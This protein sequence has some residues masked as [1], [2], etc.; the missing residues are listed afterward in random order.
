M[1]CR[2][3]AAREKFIR[4][5]SANVGRDATEFSSMSGPGRAPGAV[6]TANRVALSSAT[7]KAAVAFKRVGAFS[8]ITTTRVHK[9]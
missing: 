7:A 8:C 2:S 4:D 5:E 6:I 9:N 1:D 3:L